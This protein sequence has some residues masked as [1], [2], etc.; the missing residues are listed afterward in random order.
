MT[1]PAKAGGGQAARAGSRAPDSRLRD[2]LLVILTVGAGAVDAVCYFDLGEVFTSVVTGNLVL[3]GIDAGQGTAE[4]AWR[5]CVAISGYAIAAFVGARCLPRTPGTVVWP[6]SVTVAALIELGLLAAVFAGWVVSGGDPSNGIEFLLI[7]G[8]ALAMGTQNA[9]GQTLSGLRVSTTYVTGTFAGAVADLAT[10]TG[11]AWSIG[12]RLSIV[13]AVVLG[14]ATA[15]ILL[16][17]FPLLAPVT[18]VVT[19]A[20]VILVAVVAFRRRD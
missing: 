5:S 10:R 7:A 14:A 12:W 15:S 2:M 11:G 3:L 13:G 19:T 1:E 6:A 20:V 17:T 9:V 18:P 4:H 16:R 8:Y